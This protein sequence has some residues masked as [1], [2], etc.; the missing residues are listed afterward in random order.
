MSDQGLPSRAREDWSLDYWTWIL[1]GVGG[2][3]PDHRKTN[4]MHNRSYFLQHF[5]SHM[6]I[7]WD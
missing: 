5:E 2:L 3:K 7:E 6:Q 1:L 4:R